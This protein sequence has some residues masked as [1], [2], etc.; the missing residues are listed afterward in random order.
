[1]TDVSSMS[2]KTIFGSLDNVFDVRQSI[3]ERYREVAAKSWK[4]SLLFK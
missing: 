1:M 3:K 2:F 4:G